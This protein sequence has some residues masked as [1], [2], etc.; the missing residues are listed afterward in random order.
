MPKMEPPKKVSGARIQQVSARC[1][2]LLKSLRSDGFD[3][4]EILLG[5]V[6]AFQLAPAHAVLEAKPELREAFARMREAAS[7]VRDQGTRFL[8]QLNGI[9]RHEENVAEDRDPK[10]KRDRTT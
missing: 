7:V 1:Q 4:S 2:D 6:V 10:Q 5:V 8:Q 3:E 9:F